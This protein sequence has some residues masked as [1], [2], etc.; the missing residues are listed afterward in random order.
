MRRLFLLMYIIIPIGVLHPSWQVGVDLRCLD[1]F[2]YEAM[3]LDAEASYRFGNIRITVPLRYSHSFSHELD[4]IESG[5]AVSVYPFD[6]QGFH[7]GVS[8][9]RLGVFWGLE[10]PED[11]ILAFSEVMAGWTITFPWFY[12]EPRIAVLDLFST[13]ADRL[14]ELQEAVPQYSK[15]RLSLIAGVS[16]P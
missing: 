2:L 4:F 3:R 7:I 13:S 1:S 15:L 5:F 9:L 6:G 16:I 10:A 11:R 8:A 12:L 14:G